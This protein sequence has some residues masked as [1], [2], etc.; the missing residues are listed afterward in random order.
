MADPDYKVK[1]N[2]LNFKPQVSEDTKET[3]S[4]SNVPVE[5]IMLEANL[6]LN[7]VDLTEA[8][9]EEIKQ[10]EFDI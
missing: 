2:K 7:M 3:S 8:F 10:V 5:T 9:L 4:L 1:L 6:N